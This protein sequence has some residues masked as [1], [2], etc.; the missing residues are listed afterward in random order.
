MS[1]LEVCSIVEFY[2]IGLPATIIWIIKIHTGQK[3]HLLLATTTI[4]WYWLS[5]RDCTYYLGC[6]VWERVLLA[7]SS[8]RRLGLA[9]RW[10]GG[11][12]LLLVRTRSLLCLPEILR[13]LIVDDRRA[14][15]ILTHLSTVF[16][17]LE[18]FLPT[19]ITVSLLFVRLMIIFEVRK[20]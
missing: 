13:L 4:V 17:L 14:R 10:L 11:I 8:S 15:W 20:H 19:A 1:K 16:D 12:R 2:L 5:M 18:F 6:L 3:Q 7:L 9:L